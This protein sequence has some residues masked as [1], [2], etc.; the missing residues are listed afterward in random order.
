ML[1]IHLQKKHMFL[2]NELHPTFKTNLEK[3]SF[4]FAI[5]IRQI[6]KEL[7]A[8]RDFN[9][10]S[11]LERA[12]SSI[13]ANICESSYGR[14]GKTLLINYELH[15]K[16]P[17]NAFSGCHYSNNQGMIKLPMNPLFIFNTS[18]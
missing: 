2:D 7:Q 13:G 11:Q 18:K 14:A 1:N 6:C 15:Q 17:Q 10:A 16:R 9:T 8:N 3:L 5:E 12:S 4:E